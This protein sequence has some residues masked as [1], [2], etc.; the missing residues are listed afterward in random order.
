[1]KELLEQWL[2]EGHGSREMTMFLTIAELTGST[3][4]LVQKK[5]LE[6]HEKVV[7]LIYG[8]GA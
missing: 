2:R 3:P 1:M 5:F 7:K 6:N 8:A 4:E